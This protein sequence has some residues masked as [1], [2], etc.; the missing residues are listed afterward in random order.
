MDVF[1]KVLDLHYAVFSCFNEQEKAGMHFGGLN[2]FFRA[3][4][5]LFLSAAPCL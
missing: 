3:C 4:E 2:L 5:A 1:Y